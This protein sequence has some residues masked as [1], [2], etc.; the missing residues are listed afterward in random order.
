MQ[1][2]RSFDGS[3]GDPQFVRCVHP[4]TD[5]APWET[6]APLPPLCSV[7]GQ[8]ARSERVPSTL[9]PSAGR[10]PRS[11]AGTLLACTQGRDL[12][13]ANG[14]APW[15]AARVV[16]SN[17]LRESAARLQR[18]GPARLA[19]NTRQ[20][21]HHERAGEKKN[22]EIEKRR[23][24]YRLALKDTIAGR[25]SCRWPWRWAARVTRMRARRDPR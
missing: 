22:E 9:D 16:G 6:P 21:S 19:H 15:H 12:F 23:D 11:N 2:M 13:E 25:R 24:L 17:A 4:R 1:C 3:N 18:T 8:R 20:G 14:T 10:R 5:A 7:V